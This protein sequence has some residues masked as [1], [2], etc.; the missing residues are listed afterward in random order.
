M[1]TVAG[2]AAALVDLVPHILS[3]GDAHRNESL[4][5]DVRAALERASLDPRAGGKNNHMVAISEDSTI[6]VVP[7]TNLSAQQ[8]RIIVDKLMGAAADQVYIPWLC[9]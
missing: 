5:A 2:D 1:G 9:N 4:N 8:R 3:P 6:G 7:V